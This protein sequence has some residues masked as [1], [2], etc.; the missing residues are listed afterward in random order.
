MQVS[1]ETM[2]GLERRLTITV[3]S[4]QFEG[5]ITNKL[6]EA[7]GQVRLP[8]FRPGKVPLKE[9][10]RRFG[11][12]VRAEVAGELMQATF[13]DAV[14]QEDLAPAGQPNLEVVKMDPG[15][16]FE[17][18]ATF[19][20][21]PRIEV[22]DLSAVSVVRPQAEIQQS[23]V[24]AMI[25]RL[26][27]QKKSFEAVERG[28]EEGDQVTLDF[29]GTID[30]E[31]FENGSGEGVKF[32]VGTGQ[33]IEDFDKGVRGIAAGEEGGFDAVFPDDYQA[34]SLQGKTAHFAVTVQAV[35]APKT[36]EL[37][38]EFFK[39]F[40]VEEGGEAEFRT[41][42][43]QSMQRELDGA[44]QNQVKE[45][46]LKSLR[47]LHDFQLPEVMVQREIEA[48]KEQM[49]GQMQMYGGPNGERP[50]LPD[51]LFK[52]Q[53]EQ[54]VATGLIMNELISVN[55]LTPDQEKVEERLQNLAASYGEPEQ[56]I[57]YYRSQPEQMRQIEM[58][59][60]EDQVIDFVLES[61]DV[62]ELSSSYEDVLAGRAVPQEEVETE[63]QAAD[64]PTA[65]QE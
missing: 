64:E 3:P 49:F 19:E 13:V 65:E 56:V 44:V 53:A 52:D 29:V 46:V 6:T 7:R 54:R 10:R 59:V 43:E 21:F 36:P 15:I 11:P 25:E 33:M 42:V 57:Q 48:L 41:E 40:G 16:D 18:T 1:I 14:A 63:D 24:D 45:Q 23:D 51:D 34:E 9:V 20:V 39:E 30:G 17:F 31:P 26:Q 62:E 12:G 35:E 5:Q 55:E 32:V 8:G 4:E 22:K 2:T 47:G 27:E 37:N 58:T 38:E 60:L 61:A 28:A 50:D